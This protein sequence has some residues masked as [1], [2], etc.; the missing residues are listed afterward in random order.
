MYRVIGVGRDSENIDSRLVVYQALQAKGDF[1]EGQI[2]IRPLEMFLEKIDIDGNNI[3]RFKYI[4]D[5]E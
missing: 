1:S 5:G 2:W 4:D 3:Q